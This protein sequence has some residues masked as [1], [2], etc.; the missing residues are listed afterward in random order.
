MSQLIYGM[1]I[2]ILCDRGFHLSD[3]EHRGLK[4]LCIFAMK[5]YI[6]SWFSSRLGI[7]APKNDLLLS[8]TLLA[9]G[10]RTSLA[11]LKKLKGH[12]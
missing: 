8:Q 10:D 7:S 1:T 11:A 4:E 6:K 12:F 3:R 2:F 5:F 9:S